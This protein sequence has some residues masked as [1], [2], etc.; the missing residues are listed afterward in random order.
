MTNTHMTRRHP[1]TVPSLGP[2]PCGTRR[3]VCESRP[4]TRLLHYAVILYKVLSAQRAL[5]VWYSR[6]RLA[7]LAERAE[8][9]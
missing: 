9:L 1:F 4:R 8:R 7:S 3:T 6:I 2:G 5:S